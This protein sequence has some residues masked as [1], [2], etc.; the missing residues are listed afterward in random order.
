MTTRHTGEMPR[1]LPKAMTDSD[2][3]ALLLLARLPFLWEGAIERLYGLPVTPQSIAVWLGSVR[4][5]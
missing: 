2:R 3:R 1:Q 4:W 5:V